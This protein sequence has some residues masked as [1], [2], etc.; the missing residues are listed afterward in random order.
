MLGSG[1]TELML[2]IR[3]L[4]KRIDNHQTLG[5]LFRAVKSDLIELTIAQRVW[6][7]F[8]K[9]M[10]ELTDLFDAE[11]KK[12]FQKLAKPS[13]YRTFQISFIE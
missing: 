9:M 13:I 6:K 11:P 2:P 10:Q 5:Q 7:W 3:L 8:L 1:R 12:I 4:K